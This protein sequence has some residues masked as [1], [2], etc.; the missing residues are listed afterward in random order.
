MMNLSAAVPRVYL[1]TVTSVMA[2]VFLRRMF[3]LNMYVD[4]KVV[5]PHP[6]WYVGMQ[7]LLDVAHAAQRG[8]RRGLYGRK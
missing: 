6:C 4:L 1:H 7:V 2:E 5:V 8:A 3:V